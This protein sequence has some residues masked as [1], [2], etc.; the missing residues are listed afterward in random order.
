MFW[1]C[2]ADFVWSL[3]YS[4][5]AYLTMLIVVSAE[6][7]DIYDSDG[8]ETSEQTPYLTS[9]IPDTSEQALYLTSWMPDTYNWMD[10]IPD[11]L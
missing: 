6:S 11:F 10:T 4:A 3:W 2:F 8:P 5:A 7:W 9:C 1:D